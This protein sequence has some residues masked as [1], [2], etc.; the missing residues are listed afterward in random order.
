MSNNTNAAAIAAIN[1]QIDAI[2]AAAQANEPVDG[3]LL[4]VLT[5]ELKALTAD[6]KAKDARRKYEAQAAVREIKEGD[7]VS[8][9]FGRAANKAILSGNVHAIES[10]KSGLQFTILSGTGKASKLSTVGADAIL[11]TG[12]DI[13]R[14]EAEIAEAVA[15]KAAAEAAKAAE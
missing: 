10:D 8:F 4:T 12:E 11:L 9:V 7:A 2:N 13:A 6:D 5:L 14:V 15:A 3:G 1:A